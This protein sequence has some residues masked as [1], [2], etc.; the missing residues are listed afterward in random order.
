MQNSFIE[1]CPRS[2]P[3][4]YDSDPF[5]S[6]G[7]LLPSYS[8]SNQEA[9]SPPFS[10]EEEEN[11]GYSPVERF[12]DDESSDASSASAKAREEG[13]TCT[14]AAAVHNQPIPSTSQSQSQSH[15]QSQNQSHT[16]LT[17]EEQSPPAK[18]PRP[19]AN[20]YKSI[21]SPTYEAASFPANLMH[22]P[23]PPQSSPPRAAAS[24]S[25]SSFFSPLPKPGNRDEFHKIIEIHHRS[26]IR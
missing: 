16:T 26:F 1:L 23:P 15:N 17:P 13:P 7:P 5:L 10:P 6:G 20:S 12:S 22:S 21:F 8:P 18:K 9:D 25:S 3:D 14:P 4:R 19:A 11:I 24:A 2:S